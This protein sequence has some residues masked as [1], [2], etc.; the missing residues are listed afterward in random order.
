MR[1]P[2]ADVSGRG[3]VLHHR[4]P[5]EHAGGRCAVV[6]QQDA[7]IGQGA[8]RRQGHPAARDDAPEHPWRRIVG[9]D[10]QD[11]VAVGIGGEIQPQRP[12]LGGG[13]LGRCGTGA[14]CCRRHAGRRFPRRVHRF[15]GSHRV[16]GGG[17][18]RGIAARWSRAMP[19]SLGP[20]PAAPGRTAAGIVPR[21]TAAAA[22]RHCPRWRQASWRFRPAATAGFSCGLPGPAAIPRVR[23]ATR[24]RISPASEAEFGSLSTTGPG[25]KLR[26]AA[27]GNWSST[28]RISAH[29]WQYS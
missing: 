9:H 13:H 24:L 5:I 14:R 21:R 18:N 23:E 4:V 26:I 12:G 3:Q 28:L 27:G 16:P 1:R 2:E 22:R 8:R 15:P 7:F 11:D 6:D 25:R 29:W 10:T 20:E 19:T 17:E